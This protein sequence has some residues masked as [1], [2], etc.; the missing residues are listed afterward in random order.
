MGNNSSSSA[1]TDAVSSRVTTLEGTTATIGGRVGTL[2]TSFGVLS[3]RVNTLDTNFSS[4]IQTLEQAGTTK[5]SGIDYNIVYAQN[6]IKAF[7][8][9]LTS[10]ET[11]VSLLSNFLINTFMS[12]M[13]E[14]KLVPY[15]TSLSTRTGS[16]ETRFTPIE[17]SWGTQIGRITTLESSVSNLS[18]QNLNQRV[19]TLE[20]LQGGAGNSVLTID[21]TNKQV[22]LQLA[23][24]FCI[25]NT[26]IT[27]ADLK[28]FKIERGTFLSTVR[29][30]GAVNVPVVFS[31]SNGIIAT[32]DTDGGFTFAQPGLYRIT[33]MFTAFDGRG[34]DDNE[35]YYAYLRYKNASTSN[36]VTFL[37][38]LY[39]RSAFAGGYSVKNSTDPY[40]DTYAVGNDISK[41]TV[42]CAFPSHHYNGGG[43]YYNQF[44]FT[45]DVEIV[46]GTTYY[47]TFGSE[48]DRAG[49]GLKDTDIK[50]QPILFY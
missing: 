45:Q 3:T 24:K 14:N 20:G 33:G 44:Q 30:A 43:P 5:V 9:R 27:E 46:S 38:S 49:I 42:R 12:D 36:V 26:C 40:V 4:R 28:A 1:A 35:T 39:V 17:E 10:V 18:S 50:I 23:T 15:V 34:G 47:F 11:G 22:T 13:W 19:T 25:G 8:P 16:L 41:R 48:G 6:S 7:E 32:N 21:N 37:P 29:I 31:T 2:E